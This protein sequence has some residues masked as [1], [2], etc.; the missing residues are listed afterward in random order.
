[1]NHLAFH[2]PAEQFDAYR[3]RLKEKGGAGGAGAQP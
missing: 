3:Q 1:M 2:V